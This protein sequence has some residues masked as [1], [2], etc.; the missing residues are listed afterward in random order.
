[1]Y[2]PW[3]SKQTIYKLH[4]VLYINV[5]SGIKCGIIF[6]VMQML[7]TSYLYRAVVRG[8]AY[9]TMQACASLLMLKALQ[10]FNV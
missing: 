9:L 3:T 6:Y 10:N 1:M 4:V 7:L 8:K 5:R 2:Q